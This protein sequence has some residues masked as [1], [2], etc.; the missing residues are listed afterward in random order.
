MLAYQSAW[1][2]RYY[3]AEFTCAL[4][5]TQPMGFYPP[6][7]LTNDAKRHGVDVLPPDINASG[8]VC[9]VEDD[10]LRIGFGY[11]KSHRRTQRRLAA[12]RARAR[13]A[14]RRFHRR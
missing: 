5:N 10:A 14:P 4:L 11:V 1:L 7:V 13:Y 2:R 6:H 8:A 12:E 9:T 3:P